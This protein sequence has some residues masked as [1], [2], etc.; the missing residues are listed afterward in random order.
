MLDDSVMITASIIHSLWITHLPFKYGFKYAQVFGK[1]FGHVDGTIS[2]LGV[3]TFAA[4]N[5]LLS[6][7]SNL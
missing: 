5:T 1:A 4:V 2:A 6:M 7:K 3:D